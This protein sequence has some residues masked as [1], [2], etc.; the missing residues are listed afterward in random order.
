MRDS[1][2]T[3]ADPGPRKRFVLHRFH[4]GEAYKP[5]ADEVDALALPSDVTVVLRAAHGDKLAFEIEGTVDRAGVRWKLR[6]T[7]DTDGPNYRYF[8]LVTRLEAGAD[9]MTT[10]HL[11]KRPSP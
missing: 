2:L 8:H 7:L 4:I 5:P 10:D 9:W 6:G 3:F 1:R 11:Q